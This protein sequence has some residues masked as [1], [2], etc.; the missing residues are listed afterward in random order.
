MFE[1]LQV[2]EDIL[3]KKLDRFLQIYRYIDICIQI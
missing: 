2:D 1:G 3:V